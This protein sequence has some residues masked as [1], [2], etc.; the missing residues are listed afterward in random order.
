MFTAY[1]P[2]ANDFECEPNLYCWY[3]NKEGGPDNV[4]NDG[5]PESDI[6]RQCLPKYTQQEDKVFGWGWTDEVIQNFD[7]PLFEDFKQNGLHCEDGLA[8]PKILEDPNRPGGW[9]VSKCAK[10]QKVMQAG[11]IL[12]NP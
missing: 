9:V 6:V 4:A 2:C 10:T 1:Q 8:I 5:R 3:P 12:G 11:N 7:D